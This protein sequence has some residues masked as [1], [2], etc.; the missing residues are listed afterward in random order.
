LYFFTS[1][2]QEDERGRTKKKIENFF[3]LIQKSIPHQTMAS[4]T[5]S[6]YASENFCDKTPTAPAIVIPRVFKNITQQRIL[7]IFGKL[8]LGDIVRI[9]MVPRTNERGEE[10]WRVFVHIAWAET[11]N[12]TAV[13][14][15][16]MAED[17]NGEVKIV[18]DDPWFW[19]LHA[20]RP[21]PKKENMRRGRPAPFIDF[22]T[23]AEKPSAAVKRSAPVASGEDEPQKW[24]K[25]ARSANSTGTA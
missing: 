12:G 13:R 5:N 14:T 7:A 9:D 25:Q 6:R 20:S 4:M 11:E 19:K 17:G 21:A 8:D 16:L 22:Q 23:S 24:S 1:P 3:V 10:Y 2:S 18:Y 15:K